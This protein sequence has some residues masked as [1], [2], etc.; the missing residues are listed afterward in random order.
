[1][2][3][4]LDEAVAKVRELSEEEQ[5]YAAAMLL[6]FA[7]READKCQLTPEQVAEVELAR[8]EAKEGLFATDEEMRELWGGGSAFKFPMDSP[9][10]AS[11]KRD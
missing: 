7:D 4:L 6:G 8:K 9:G 3:K 1:M 11:T 2:T 5:D 10:T